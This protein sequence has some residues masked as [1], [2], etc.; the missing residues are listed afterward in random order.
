MRRLKWLQ[1]FRSG[2]FR[3]FYGEYGNAVSSWSARGYV[4]LKELHELLGEYGN[5]ISNESD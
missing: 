4:S 3:E 1:V 5:A 2:T